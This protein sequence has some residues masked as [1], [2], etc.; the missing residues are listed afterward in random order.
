MNKLI[1]I[2][3]RRDDADRGIKLVILLSREHLQGLLDMTETPDAVASIRRTIGGDTTDKISEIVIETCAGGAQGKT[4]YDRDVR[5]VPDD[6]I[7]MLTL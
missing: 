2:L 1:K 4:E 6:K 5:E 7:L 3:I